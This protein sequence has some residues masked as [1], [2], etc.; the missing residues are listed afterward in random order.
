MVYKFDHIGITV[1]SL[2]E[3]QEQ[4]ERIH[5]CFHVQSGIEVR[6]ALKEVSIHNPDRLSISLHRREKHISIE[7]IEYPRVS[8][9]N[10]SILPCC[11][12]AETPSGYLESFKDAVR[13][14]LDR[15]LDG[16][17]FADIAGLLAEHA[18]FNAVV[19]PVEDLPAEEHFWQ[20]LRFKQIY[21]DSELVILTL[22]S[23]IPPAQDDYIVLYKVDFRMQYYTDMEG[24]NEVALLCHSCSADLKAF[25]QHVFKSSVDTLLVDGKQVELGYLRSPSGVLAELLSVRLAIH[26]R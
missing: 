24:I 3:A 12:D 2:M 11:Y 7:L 9:K 10:G 23:L 26:D 17:S 21:S 25:P 5:P 19:I 14:K 13:K 1:R 15:S 8:T 16:Y 20:S 18:E 22:K 6:N 4:I